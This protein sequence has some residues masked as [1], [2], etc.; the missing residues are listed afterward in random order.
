[1][2]LCF[3]IVLAFALE[4]RLFPMGYLGQG[5]ITRKTAG[6]EGYPLNDETVS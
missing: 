5:N 2:R 6:L 4:N 1:M 3:T